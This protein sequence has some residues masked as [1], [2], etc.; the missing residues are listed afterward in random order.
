MAEMQA[1][2][3]EL[4]AMSTPVN[5]A[6]PAKMVGMLSTPVC[7]SKSLPA[8]IVAMDA[9]LEIIPRL[10]RKISETL[11]RLA[12][13]KWVSN[14][15]TT[16][17]RIAIEQLKMLFFAPRE[18]DD[19]CAITAYNIVID[20]MKTNATDDVDEKE[21][22]AR[23]KINI[24]DVVALTCCRTISPYDRRGFNNWVETWLG[25]DKKGVISC[26]RW[27]LFEREYLPTR[28][29]NPEK[30]LRKS[31]RKRR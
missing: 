10:Q 28:D 16:D 26:S 7:R 21:C 27:Q 2:L 6:G 11:V 8:R 18:A 24:Q 14:P 29:K 19:G 15:N 20:L 25:S 31:S 13:C 3:N 5:I 9:D 4:R 22:L 12:V 23:L 30:R 1:T 17:L